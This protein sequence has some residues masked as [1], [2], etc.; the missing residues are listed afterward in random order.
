MDSLTEDDAPDFYQNRV[1]LLEEWLT[2]E[3][4][5]QFTEAEKAFLVEQYES[6]ETPL[7]VEY[8]VG[9]AQLFEH[10]PTVV[11]ITMLDRKSVV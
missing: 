6:L 11:M 8:A 2:E 4:A 3:A 9:W 5:D 10:A 1:R 7:Y